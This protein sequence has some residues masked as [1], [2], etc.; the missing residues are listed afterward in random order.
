[1]KPGQ[2]VAADYYAVTPLPHLKQVGMCMTDPGVFHWLG[3]NAHQVRRVAP[4]ESDILLAYD[5]I[6]H[7]NSCFSCRAKNMTAGELLA[8]NFDETFGIYHQALPDSAFWVWSDMFDPFHNARDSFFLVEGTLAGSWKG[9]PPEV[10][11]L[12]WNLE[13][14]KDSLTWFSG[15]NPQQPIAHQQLIAGFYDRANAAAEARREAAEAAGIP[16][17]RGL[18]YTTWSDD[19]SKLQDFAAAARA[20][21][22]DYLKSLPSK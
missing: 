19:Y 16:G 6:R 21:W 10:S 13:K 2:I 8:W 9:L 3:K 22:P 1:L 14:L 7:A 12:N 18:M 5:E 15:L 4:P 17:V 20:A 11:I